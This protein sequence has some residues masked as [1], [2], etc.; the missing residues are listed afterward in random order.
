M[1]RVVRNYQAIF[2]D[3]AM[4]WNIIS[5]V[6]LFLLSTL[7]TYIAYGYTEVAGG[8]VVQDIILD[9]IP[10]YDVAPLFF[11]GMLL[12]IIIPVG[13][14]AF[15]PRKIPF[16]LEA[17]A[18]FFVVRSLFMIMTHLAPPN[19]AYYN[20]IEH[21][22]QLGDVLFSI[23]SGTDMFFSGHTGYPFLFALI[24]WEKRLWRYFF[25]GFS[26]VMALTVLVGH[27]HYSIDV[28]AAF[29]IAHGVFV[30][31]RRLFSREYA[32]MTA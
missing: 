5:S 15:D 25:I 29:F 14:G 11:G 3:K 6:L 2:K 30:F 17:S 7:I 19:F 22:R 20:V 32:F 9:H 23:S 1:K 26:L 12:L 21:E 4:L 18:S 13:I 28:F 8:S 24:F 31:S 27:L 16:V 10:V